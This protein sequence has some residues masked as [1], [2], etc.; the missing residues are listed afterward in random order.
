MM[1]LAAA[2]HSDGARGRS[3]QEQ[4]EPGCIRLDSAVIQRDSPI[5]FYFQL[6]TYIE[7]KISSKQWAP[8]QLIPSEEEFGRTLGVSRTVVRQAMASLESKS[9]I[10]KHDG[11]RSSVSY[12]KFKVGLMQ[13]LCGFHEDAVASGQK[14]AAKVL[15]LGVKPAKVEVAEALGLNEGDPVI[16]L[17]PAPLSGWRAGG[18]R[19][20]LFARVPMPRVGSRR[21]LHA[22][23]V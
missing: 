2:P 8:G 15:G 20:H 6:V 9:L 16:V 21:L 19:S 10:V 3:K 13:S 12:P 4:P 14:P 5:P 18:S 7:E 1:K 23:V 22:F 17:E 11:K